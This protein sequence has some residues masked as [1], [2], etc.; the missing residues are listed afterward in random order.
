[1]FYSDDN[2]GN[3]QQLSAWRRKWSINEFT[4]FLSQLACQNQQLSWR[5]FVNSTSSH[6]ALLKQRALNEVI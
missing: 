4:S 6:D 1:M 5:Q 3:Y 2:T